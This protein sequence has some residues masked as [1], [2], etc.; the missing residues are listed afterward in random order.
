MSRRTAE[1][2]MDAQ[3][4]KMTFH[5]DG[6][7]EIMD[8]IIL[9]PNFRGEADR[10][11]NSARNFNVALNDEMANQLAELG[12]KIRTVNV[13]EIRDDADMPAVLP[14]INVKV[15]FNSKKPP[16]VTLFSEYNGKRTR[17][18][19]NEDTVGELDAVY[20]QTCGLIAR[21]YES[22]NFPGKRTLYLQTLKVIQEPSANFGGK[23]D[24]WM[25]DENLPFDNE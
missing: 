20:I 17:N 24:D 25:D 19:L 23:F 18:N 14:F 2:F 15:N 6:S 9:W 21:P 5:Q 13:E 11:N 16:V 7:I 8:A 4:T 3:N 22:K 12:I 1:A 10:F